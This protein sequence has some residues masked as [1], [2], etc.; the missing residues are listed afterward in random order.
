MPSE[1]AKVIVETMKSK[2]ALQRNG[3][4]I[5]FR[6]L[7]NSLEKPKAPEQWMTSR[8]LELPSS[9]QYY[10]QSNYTS[11]NR[12]TSLQSKEFTRT[13]DIKARVFGDQKTLVV[14]NKI[15]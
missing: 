5:T 9:S 3:S 2:R 12:I 6:T 10:Y 4:D 14:S 1:R 8:N 7:N 13:N 15:N 11:A